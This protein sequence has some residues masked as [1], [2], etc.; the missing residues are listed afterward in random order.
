MTRRRHTLTERQITGR[1]GK[2]SKAV[3]QPHVVRD[4]PG[5]RR[6]LVPAL[7]RSVSGNVAVNER[8]HAK[9]PPHAS[10]HGGKQ[11]VPVILQKIILSIG[12]KR[13]RIG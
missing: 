12:M 6:T 13:R 11:L 10:M 4:T 9:V 3:A 1:F 7:R 2:D 5:V 8:L